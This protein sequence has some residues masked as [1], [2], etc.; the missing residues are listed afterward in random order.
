MIGLG[1]LS[2]FEDVQALLKSKLGEFLAAEQKLR[3]LSVNPSVTIRSEASGLLAAQKILEGELGTAQAKIANFQA[4]AW[5][6]S[7][8]IALGDIGTRLISH[9]QKVASLEARAGSVV[10]AGLLTSPVL[11][12]LGIAAA[13]AVLFVVLRK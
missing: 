13:A 12:I 10:T 2:A 7:D 5:S 8:A 1:T 3:S 6:F 11:P 4:G 9:L